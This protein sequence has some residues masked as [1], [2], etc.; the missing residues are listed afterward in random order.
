[1]IRAIF[2]DFNGVIINDERI[3]LQAYREVLLNEEVALSDEDYFASLG[4]DDVAFVRAVFARVGRQ[5]N[6][7]SLQSIIQRE[8][9]RHRELIKEDLPVDSG[10]VTLIKAAARHYQLGVV[11]M[12]VRG[13]IDHVLRQVGLDNVFTVFVTAGQ[14]ANHKPAPDCYRRALELLNEKRRAEQ[15]QPVPANECLVVEDAPLGIEA[16]RAAGMRTL[17]VTN[18]VS[19]SELRAAGA[20]VVTRSL[21]DWN[22]DAVRLVFDDRR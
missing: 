2:F 9:E 15:Q 11:S 22:V 16:A 21:A 20:E 17:G 13:E 1:M 19:D 5:L 7:L 10:V 14:V 12:A 3:H 4:M 6:D 18:T 8:H